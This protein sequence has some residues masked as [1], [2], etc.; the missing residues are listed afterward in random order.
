MVTI[1][2]TGLEGEKLDRK[3]EVQYTAHFNSRDKVLFA[4]C[5]ECK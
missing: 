2:T 5:V 3:S 1:Y 4:H